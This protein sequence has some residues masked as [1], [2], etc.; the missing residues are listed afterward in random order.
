MCGGDSREGM[1]GSVA[2]HA[3]AKLIMGLKPAGP[4]DVRSYVS[5]R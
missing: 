1:T 4:E 2:V 5:S 3:E